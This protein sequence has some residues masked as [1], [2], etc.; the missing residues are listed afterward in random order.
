MA[1][2]ELRGARLHRLGSEEQSTD[3]AVCRGLKPREMRREKERGVSGTGVRRGTLAAQ[4]DEPRAWKLSLWF[5]FIAR[6]CSFSSSMWSRFM[7]Q[8]VTAG[9][10]RRSVTTLVKSVPSRS[11]VV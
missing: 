8:K 4:T 1:L 3:A 9:M 5:V 11:N 10:P 7:S 2:Q 6:T